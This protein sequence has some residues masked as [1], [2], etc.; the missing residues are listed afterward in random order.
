MRYKKIIVNQS[1]RLLILRLLFWIPDALMVRI[2]YRIKMGFWPNLSNPTRFT[3]KMQLYKIYYRNPVL[4]KCIDKYAVRDYVEDK[5]FAS[6]L[7]EIYG[8]Y[9]SADD[10]EFANLPTSF[11]IKST[12]GAGCNNVIICRDKHDLN[13]GDTINTVNS[14]LNLN[15]IVNP[16]RE[17][18]YLNIKPRILVEKFICED[19][20]LNGFLTDYKFY[21]FQGK[22]HSLFVLTDRGD[23]TKLNFYNRNWTPLSVKSDSYNSSNE[24]INKPKNFDFMIEM[25][26]ALSKDFPHVRVDLYNID[27][28][29]VFGEMT[30]Y[31][32]SGYW[33]FDPDLYD[34][35]LGNQ[36]DITSFFDTK[37]N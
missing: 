20:N 16:G 30:F 7:N 27:G 34:F 35:E 18:G 19:S 4:P 25:A 28:R 33:G 1:I 11:V 13:I 24:V 3:E 5:G 15:Q 21:C 12:D 2:Q 37:H 14:W 31:S 36:F 9:D 26:E 29:V 22:V 32:G 6:C 10:I 8:V 23:N 17:W